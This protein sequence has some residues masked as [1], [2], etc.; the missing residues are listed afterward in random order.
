MAY[1]TPAEHRKILEKLENRTNKI[2][3]LDM[4]DKLVHVH[5]KLRKAMIAKKIEIPFIVKKQGYAPLN[6]IR[7][8]E[9]TTGVKNEGDAEIT[10]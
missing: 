1:R 4:N 8:W 7:E 2:Q 5:T 3:P 9:K 6:A 10:G